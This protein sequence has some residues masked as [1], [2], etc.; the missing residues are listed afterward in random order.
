M[1]K[2]KT[3]SI[4]TSPEDKKIIEDASKIIGLDQS[5]FCRTYS[6]QRAREILKENKEE[7]SQ[8]D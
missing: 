2:R 6:I 5:A 7:E 4:Y 1:T 3:I 8:S